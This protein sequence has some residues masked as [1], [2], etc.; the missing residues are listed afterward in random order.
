MR[1][2][3]LHEMTL[4]TPFAQP[5]TKVKPYFDYLEQHGTIVGEQD[6]LDISC[7]KSGDIVIYGILQDNVIT[8]LATFTPQTDNLWIQH[9][10]HT[11]VPY[12]DKQHIFKLLWF[13]KSQEGKQL[14]S[15]GTHT[16]DGIKFVKSLAKTGRFALS[17]YNTKTNE[18]VPYDQA[19]DGPENTPYR[20]NITMTDWRVLIESDE[21]PSFPRFDDRMVKWYYQVFE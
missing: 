2:E 18:K 4:T 16:M 6:G 10:V 15:Y 20:S 3:E 8:S 19:I 9:I 21:Y 13:I 14:L 12:R 7:V 11:L 5:D 17:W 1:L